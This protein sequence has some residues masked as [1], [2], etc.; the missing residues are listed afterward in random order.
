MKFKGFTLA[1]VLITMTIIGV[2]A[3]LTTPALF[4]NAGTAQVGP[5]LAKIK[6]TIENA[7]RQ[8]MADEDVGSLATLFADINN[9]NDAISRRY[10]ELLGQYMRLEGGAQVPQVSSYYGARG[11]GVIGIYYGN[12][13]AMLPMQNIIANM[14]FSTVEGANIGFETYIVTVNAPLPVNRNAS[15]GVVFVDINGVSNPNRFGK[16]IFAFYLRND[17]MLTPYGERITALAPSWQ[18]L[19]NPANDTPVANNAA[20]G[21]ACTATIFENNLRVTYDD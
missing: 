18:N 13:F 7:N 6:S 15:I 8:L 12:R 3:A 10:P 2:V 11:A 17:G 16:D 20:A 9:D 21:L 14:T 1:E 4:H 19:C 5:K